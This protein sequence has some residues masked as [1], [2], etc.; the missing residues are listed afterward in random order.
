MK[1]DK[2][3]LFEMMSKLD[4]KFKINED[5]ESTLPFDDQIKS[6]LRNLYQNS[7]YGKAGQPYIDNRID[8]LFD[9]QAKWLSMAKQQY[10][11]DEIART[12]F[13]YEQ[14]LNK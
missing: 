6:N 7:T 3:R 10:N 1:K 5:L 8:Q 13:K 11:A 9:I 4:S 12:L 2:Q 14:N